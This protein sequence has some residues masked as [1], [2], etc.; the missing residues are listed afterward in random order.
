[1]P[2]AFPPV[3]ILALLVALI[4]TQAAYLGRPGRPNYLARLGLSVAAVGAGEALAALGVGAGLAAGDLHVVN[5]L[6]LL[7]VA[8]WGGTRWARR[9]NPGV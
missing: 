9:Q 8:Q 7:T 4:G 1:M 3:F 2:L 6:V 5:D